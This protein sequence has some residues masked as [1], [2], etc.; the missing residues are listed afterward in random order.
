MEEGLCSG[1]SAL[2][3]SIMPVLLRLGFSSLGSRVQPLLA[4]HLGQRYQ[5]VTSQGIR[6]HWWYEF[7]NRQT[8]SLKKGGPVLEHTVSHCF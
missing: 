7:P 2:F 5:L 3:F 6:H 8:M 1:E 4:S